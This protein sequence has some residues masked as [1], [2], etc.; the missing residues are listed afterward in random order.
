MCDILKWRSSCVGCE[1]ALLRVVYLYLHM[2]AAKNS[3][4]H[5][6]FTAACVFWRMTNDRCHTSSYVTVAFCMS[7][8]G[9]LPGSLALMMIYKAHRAHGLG[10]VSV[11]IYIH[12]L[13]SL[14]CL[15]GLIPH[16]HTHTLLPK[17]YIIDCFTCVF[18]ALLSVP[19]LLI[20]LT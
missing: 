2:L 9:R 4:W 6:L 3:R 20:Y 11:S 5:G 1:T 16:T 10:H 12:L 13:L 7:L 15:G 14:A 18:V 8:V 19:L 17:V